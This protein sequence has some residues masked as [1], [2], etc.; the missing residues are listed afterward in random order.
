MKVADTM[1]RPDS[2]FIVLA[3]LINMMDVQ[4]VQR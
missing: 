4:P 2:Y 3:L 1:K